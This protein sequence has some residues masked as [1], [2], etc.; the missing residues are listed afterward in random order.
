MYDALQKELKSFYE[1]L[2][3]TAYEFNQRCS[4]VLEERFDPNASAYDQK[5]VQYQTIA[6]LCQPVL[7]E[8]CRFY[9]ETA[10]MNASTQGEGENGRSA[11]APLHPGGWLYRKNRHLFIDQDPVLYENSRIPFYS[12]C[13]E[14]GDF[15]YHFAFNVEKVFQSG[16]RGLYERAEARLLRATEEERLYLEN[17]MTG[18]SAIRTVCEKFAVLAKEKL[19]RAQSEEERIRLKV[20]A[21]AAART[22]WEVPQNTYEALNAILL[23]TK[24]IAGLE[25][26]N[27]TAMGRY[28]LLLY[29]FYEKDIQ[30]GRF[31]REEIY[32]LICEFLMVFNCHT[33]HDEKHV[34]T[35]NYE[36]YVYTLGG[37]DEKGEPVWN[38]LTE[39]FLRAHR[40]HKLIFPKIKCRYGKNSPKAYLDAI[41]AD[42]VRGRTYILYQN[43]DAMIPAL[44]KAGIDLKDARNYC[45]LGCWEPVVNESTNEH[46]GYVNLIQIFAH[47]LYGDWTH[48]ELVI[49]P[50]DGAKSF[51]QVYEITMENLERVLSHKC[52][53]AYRGRK[54][55]DRVDPL[56][57]I[58]AAYDSCIEN[59][60][61]YTAGGTKYHLDE[62]VGAGIV[63]LADSLLAIR[64]LCF[65]RKLC[66]LSELIQALR[67]NWEGC[68]ALRNAALKCRHWGDESVESCELMAG[69]C[70]D[71]YQI[72]EKIP[73]LYGG[74]V[75]LGYM[76][77]L[78]MQR[79]C[80]SLRATPD[81]RRNGDY[82]ERGFTPSRNHPA[83]AATSV[84]N[85]MRWVDGS[86]IAA[87]SVMN[88]TLPLKE[89]HLDLLGDYVRSSAESGIGAFQINCVSREELLAARKDP[90]AH[91][92]IVVR[93]CGYSAQ[94]VSLSDEIQT[95]FL[96]RN[97][98][99]ES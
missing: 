95:E 6:E 86:E 92:D 51:D 76:L 45:L 20:I 37:C 62:V 27:L 42:I 53:A 65:E 78:E 33:D 59:G 56:M 2:D 12:W 87:N 71:L 66:T 44:L 25:G 96:S 34:G 10:T 13:G 17:T 49:Q 8:N 39:M 55:W 38:E 64:E 57:L 81:G 70:H 11:R 40:E 32:S 26:V 30:T 67:N 24:A 54:I 52:R 69:I 3:E 85:C 80:P 75:T 16:L 5:A 48:P 88:V 46:C 28:D 90:Q 77:Y 18:L 1:G 82:F 73:V 74:R 35:H 68:E 41:N 93:V 22:P 99:E 47:S 23:L 61:D 89:E 79:W 84:I 15:R 14:Y 72:A 97:F 9:Y 36:S 4:R 98:Y 29:P 50:L 7:F 91:R 31:T 58:S 94:F 43:D 19:L 63:N 21:E 83:H 60:R